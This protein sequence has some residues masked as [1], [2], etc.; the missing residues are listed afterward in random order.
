MLFADHDLAR[1]VEFIDVRVCTECAR[2]LARE[3]PEHETTVL[4]VAGGCALFAGIA[5]PLTQ[6]VGVGLHG[7]V[8]DDDIDA[9]ESFYR[10]RNAP[11]QIEYCPLADPSLLSLL[12][13]RGYRTTEHSNALYRVLGAGE[14]FE[15]CTKHIRIRTVDGT[16]LHDW[17]RIVTSGFAS[18]DEPPAEMIDIVECSCRL[19]GVTGLLAD[20]DGRP[21][22]GGS[23][24]VLDRVASVFGQSTL[25]AFRGRGVQSA[26]LRA[27]L[28]VGADAGC[29]VAVMY[30]LCG[31]SSQRN[32]ERQGFRIAYTR[33][34][35]VR[36][37]D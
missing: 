13:E 36:T 14:S 22:G 28:A 33:S 25:P 26:I 5:S 35:L 3:H 12:T 6:A 9:L 11:V 4:E 37:W 10:S 18:T 27:S 15:N 29:D 17:A 21:A 24:A 23:V 2:L 20:I 1:R 7:P 30:T 31:S 34:K 19:K 8:T 32:A 16:Q